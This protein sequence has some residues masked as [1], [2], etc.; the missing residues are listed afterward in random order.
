MRSVF[1]LSVVSNLFYVSDTLCGL[2]CQLECAA[3]LLYCV[4]PFSFHSL[5]TLVI[6]VDREVTGIGVEARP[7]LL[8]CFALLAL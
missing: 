7:V 3:F 5:K 8:W 2:S 4:P 6:S 1:S